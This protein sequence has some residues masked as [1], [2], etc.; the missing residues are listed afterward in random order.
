MNQNL[1]SN[2]ILNNKNKKTRTPPS[3]NVTLTLEFSVTR[4][5]NFL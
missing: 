4:L 3:A 1:Y 2:V 5:G